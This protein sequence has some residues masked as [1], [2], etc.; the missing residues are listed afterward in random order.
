MFGMA[1][2]RPSSSMQLKCDVDFFVHVCGQK[3]DTLSNYF[4][5]IQPYD[6]TFQFLSKLTQF[7]DYFFGNYHKFEL[8]NFAR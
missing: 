6:E 5:S 3:A 8:L 2:T 4:D 1:L 7:L